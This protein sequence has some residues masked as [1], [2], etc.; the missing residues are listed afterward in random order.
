[1]LVRT[2]V[3]LGKP[4]QIFHLIQIKETIIINLDDE[5]SLATE[6]GHPDAAHDGLVAEVA[7]GVEEVPL[8]EV[9]VLLAL[10]LQGHLHILI[11]RGAYTD[12]GHVY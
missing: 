8:H 2:V 11:C 9:S 1:M 5:L 3:R 7:V 10:L 6:L 12:V 4:G